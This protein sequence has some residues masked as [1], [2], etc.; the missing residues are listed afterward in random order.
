MRRRIRILISLRL[1]GRVEY[2]NAIGLCASRKYVKYRC[3][4]RIIVKLDG[5]VQMIHDVDEELKFMMHTHK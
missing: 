1:A 2:G 4:V 3:S 5:P